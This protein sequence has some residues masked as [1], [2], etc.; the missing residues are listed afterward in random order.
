M[1]LTQPDTHLT[2]FHPQCRVYSLDTVGRQIV[3]LRMAGDFVEADQLQHA[4]EDAFGCKI[5]VATKEAK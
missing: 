5:V 3:Q 2:P 1:N 4:L